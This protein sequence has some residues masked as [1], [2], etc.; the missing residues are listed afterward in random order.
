MSTKAKKTRKKAAKKVAKTS[1]KPRSASAKG[2]GRPSKFNGKKIVKL[3][4]EN[5]RRKGTHGFKTFTLYGGGKTYEQVLAAG[6]RRQDVAF[7]LEKKYIKL[8]A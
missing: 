7:D 1:K 8:S 3:V 4:Q 6:G 5:P 2:S